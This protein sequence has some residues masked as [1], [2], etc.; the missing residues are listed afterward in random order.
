MDDL[1]LHSMFRVIDSLNIV[2]E[3]GYW[4]VTA[5]IKKEG[6]TFHASNDDLEVALRSIY[7]QLH[8]EV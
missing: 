8:G 1:T 6:A 3:E 7:N 5:E 4:R 2:K